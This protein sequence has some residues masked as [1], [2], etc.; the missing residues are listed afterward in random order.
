MNV[1]YGERLDARVKETLGA[2]QKQHLLTTWSVE[3]ER[4]LTDAVATCEAFDDTE[5][6]RFGQQSWLMCAHFGLPGERYVSRAVGHLVHNLLALDYAATRARADGTN[7]VASQ[8][9]GMVFEGAIKP[10]SKKE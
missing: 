2:M 5:R 10:T 4:L 9:L 7:S 8:V 6:A 1:T 3:Y